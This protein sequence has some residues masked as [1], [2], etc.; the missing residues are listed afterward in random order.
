MNIPERF[1][2]NKLPDKSRFYS[3]LK[4]KCVSKK[5]YSH[6]VS[7]W[8]AFKMKTVGDYHDIYLKT[9]VSLL[10]DAFEKFIGVYLEYYV[11]HPSHYFS[12]PGLSWD[13][14]LDD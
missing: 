5:D 8:N 14:M 4:D 7:V 11:L 2:D 10:A 9:D 6:T 3:S 13:E 12:N 1:F